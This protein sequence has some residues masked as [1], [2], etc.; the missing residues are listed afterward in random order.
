MDGDFKILTPFNFFRF[1]LLIVM[2]FA[3]T[4]NY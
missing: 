1:D 4:V 3:P 2:R